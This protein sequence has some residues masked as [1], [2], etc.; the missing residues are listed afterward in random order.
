[1]SK[2][3]VIIVTL[4]EPYAFG[5]VSG[6]W[7]YV[8][9]K[10]LSRRGYEVRCLSVTTNQEWARLALDAVRPFGVRLSLYPLSQGGNWLSR[11]WRTFR[12]PFSYSL[13]D[14]LRRDLATEIR[15]GYDVLHLEQLWAGYLAEKLPRTLVSVH[16]LGA[17]D[18]RNLKQGPWPDLRSRLLI[19]S[20]ASLLR[21]LDAMSTLSNRLAES[22]QSINNRARVF[23]VPFGVDPSLY[24]FTKEDR[25]E[26]PT[27]GFMANLRW[28][29]GYLAAKRLLSCVFPM[30]KRSVPNAKVLIAGWGAREAL[31][32]FANEPDVTIAGDVPLAQ[33]YF[34]RLQVL[35][36]PVPQG[37]GVKVKV[38]EA[39]AW[40]IPVV[41]TSDGVEG[42]KA[43][44]GEHCFVADEDNLFAGKI[45]E[46]LRDL[47]LRRRLRKC[48]RA[49][50][51]AQHSPIPVVN[52]VEQIYRVL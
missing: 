21:K 27:I 11:K 13:S 17:L 3:R 29:P 46:V 42:I 2:S 15:T 5:H 35:A 33:A 31:P 39:M 32:E 44:S 45:I 41:T 28:M 20:E 52:R 38:L 7:Y 4:S 16:H 22:I 51:E 43:I 30:V 1:M 26:E 34:E 18:L 48:A 49:L 25:V 14:S 9:L 47:E 12:R 10:E 24:S 6:R 8:L 36:Y 50:V 40:G 23:V 19:R 37:S